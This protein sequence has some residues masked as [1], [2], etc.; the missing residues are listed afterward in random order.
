[1]KREY[2]KQLILDG[3]VLLSLSG[4]VLCG[5]LEVMVHGAVDIQVISGVFLFFFNTY[6]LHA[7]ISLH[8]NKASIGTLRYFWCK[9]NLKWIVLIT[10]MV[11]VTLAYHALSFASLLFFSSL[12][13]PIYSMWRSS[14]YLDTK[15]VNI[16]YLKVGAAFFAIMALMMG[17]VGMDLFDHP[18]LLGLM[19]GHLLINILVGDMRDLKI[20]KLQNKVTSAWDFKKMKVSLMVMSCLGFG[21][22]SYVNSIE[23]MLSFG[24]NAALL[25]FTHEKMNSDFYNTYELTH[26][27]PLLWVLCAR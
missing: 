14:L 17:V 4:A 23:W 20:D 19:S 11:W 2:W 12:T 27:I 3:N 16:P 8:K 22:S 26:F 1:L 10:M 25:L 7:C 6:G 18:V 5:Y 15:K 13:A 21:V 9:E 24:S